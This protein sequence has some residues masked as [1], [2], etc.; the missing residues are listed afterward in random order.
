MT[1]RRHPVSSVAVM[2]RSNIVRHTGSVT[3]EARAQLLGQRGAVLWLTGLSGSGKSTVGYALEQQL[4]HLGRACF[5]LDGDNIRHGLNSDLNFSPEHRRENIRRI[6]EVSALFADAGLL[7][8]TSFISPYK[9]DR[10]QVR[11]L[12]GDKRFVEVYVNAPL[13]ICESRDPKGLYKKAR[14]GE[15]KDFTGISA[16]YEAPEN[17]EIILVHSDSPDESANKIVQYLSTNG[18]LQPPTVSRSSS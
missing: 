10:Q 12:C 11:E 1:T 4:H 15:L 6:G 7:T 3:R 17:P 8:I 9:R 14:S 2:S 16:P 18:F 13:E 5:N